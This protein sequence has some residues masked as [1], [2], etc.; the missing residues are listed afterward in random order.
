MLVD[1]LKRLRDD[2]SWQTKTN[3]EPI[4]HILTRSFFTTEIL[5]KELELIQS[6]QYDSM[7]DRHS[8][9]AEAYSKTFHWV[10]STDGLPVSDIRSKI[11]FKSWLESKNGIFWVSGKPGSGKSTL[12]KYICDN[13]ITM[14]CLQRWAGT[15]KLHTAKFYFWNPGTDMQKSTQGLLQSLLYEIL[16]QCPALIPKV[17]EQRW[18]LN[19]LERMAPWSH[20]ELKRTFECL[21]NCASTSQKF[22]FFIDGLDEYNG[23]HFEL[24]ENLLNIVESSPNIKL[25]LSSRPWN[26]FEDALGNEDNR[27][28]YMQDLTKEDIEVYSINKLRIPAKFASQ[29]QYQVQHHNLA[30]EIVKRA[31]GVFLWVYLVVRSLQEGLSNGDDISMLQKRLEM[32]PTDLD[33]YFSHIMKS[34]D[35]VYQQKLCCILRA[36]LSVE[37]PLSLIAYSFLDEG[38]VDPDVSLKLALVPFNN[39]Q[40]RARETNT[41]RR[42]NGISKG[43]LEVSTS[44]KYGYA[45]KNVEFLHRTVRD[46]L[47]TKEA[48][49][50]LNDMSPKTFNLFLA[51]SRALLAELKV[52]PKLNAERATIA[53]CKILDFAS[54]AEEQRGISDQP[55]LT[56]L[57]CTGK[58]FGLF[59]K[60][61][62]EFLQYTVRKGLLIYVE[63]EVMQQPAMVRAYG[64]LLL[65][66]ALGIQEHLEHTPTIENKVTSMVE[67]LLRH[68]IR[69]NSIVKKIHILHK[70]LEEYRNDHLSKELCE[71][72]RPLLLSAGI[73]YF[74]EILKDVALMFPSFAT[75]NLDL[76]LSTWENILSHGFDPNQSFADGQTVWTVFLEYLCTRKHWGKLFLEKMRK[77]AILFLNYGA[78][79]FATYRYYT[80]TTDLVLTAFEGL[81]KFY[82]DPAF[83]ETEEVVWELRNDLKDVLER[84][85]TYFTSRDTHTRKRKRSS[86]L[87]PRMRQHYSNLS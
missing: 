34:V 42:I 37:T 78:N 2:F 74:A 58:R 51:M 31:Q 72:L 23:D 70:Y 44:G 75:K 12:M 45:T 57:A 19:R 43:L 73:N 71:S 61:R 25:C 87:E 60:S 65:A 29:H 21:Q 38:L 77:M 14:Q 79:P 63:E 10:F 13:T 81:N 52:I 41:K 55:T 59:V 26:C 53:I 22:C 9:I 40:T 35:G 48:Q 46:F 66:A 17:C 68:G 82:Y 85:M 80:G 11:S 62:L 3:L 30:M 20:S 15:S 86:S 24:L 8:R 67:L 6:L 83:I 7:F 1:E 32:L 47:L 4:A 28:L 64:D 18:L 84:E 16:R 27:K 50:T 56:D 33:A 54:Y 76:H 39:A 36:A 49:N 5:A 69:P